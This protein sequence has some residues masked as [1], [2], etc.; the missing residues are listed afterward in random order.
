MLLP[1]HKKKVQS[2]H[3]AVLLIR[4]KQVP[5]KI[6]INLSE[7]RWR[8][9]ESTTEGLYLA[10]CFFKAK[11]QIIQ[12]QKGKA[13]FMS[14]SFL[15]H[16]VDHS[17]RCLGSG[18]YARARH[19]NCATRLN[20]CI[21]QQHHLLCKQSIMHSA[22]DVKTQRLFIGAEGLYLTSKSLANIKMKYCRTSL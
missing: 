21:E 2:L 16:P 5:Q 17:S 22:E 13:I 11:M 3:T 4:Q 14:Y 15:A 6:G 7:Y 9:W 20:A 12:E 8:I 10:A 19:L 18:T 1:W